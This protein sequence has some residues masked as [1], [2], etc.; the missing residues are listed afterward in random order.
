MVVK[1]TSLVKYPTIGDGTLL[2]DPIDV[3]IDSTVTELWL[4]IDVC[5]KMEQTF[6]LKWDEDA[7]LYFADENIREQLHDDKVKLKFRIETLSTAGLDFHFPYAAFDLVIQ[8]PLVNKTARYFPLKR[9]EK[10][11]QYT[12]GRVFLQEAYVVADYERSNFGIGRATHWQPND[13]GNQGLTAIHPPSPSSSSTP[14]GHEGGLGGGMIAAAVIPPLSVLVCVVLA[15]FWYRRRQNGRREREFE[16]ELQTRMPIP[17]PSYPDT[18]K[19]DK[20]TA[21]ELDGQPRHELERNERMPEM[22]GGT[23]AHELDHRDGR[24]PELQ[25][26]KEAHEVGTRNTGHSVD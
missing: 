15:Y 10:T 20:A 24:L 11:S 22:Q 21:V 8:P 25:T 6:G 13:E 26:G 4:P 19:A 9:A 12:L 23:L 18:I 1:V 3:Y 17:P 7:Q 16:A 2:N 5:N 14:Y